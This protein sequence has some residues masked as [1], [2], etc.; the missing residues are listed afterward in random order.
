MNDH[1]SQS[2]GRPRR[3]ALLAGLAYLAL[4]GGYAWPVVANLTTHVAGTGGDAWQNLWNM[5]WF[6][7]ALSSGHNPYF[8]PLLHHPQGITLV[9]QTLNPF[10]CLLAWPLA[11]VFGLVA[12]YNLVFLLSFVAAGLGMYWLG[13]ELGLRPLAA[14]S[15]GA[16][17]TF[18]PYHFAHGTGH[19]QLVAMEWVP[20]YL[21]LLRRLWRRPTLENGLATG[22]A[23]ALVTFCD[24]YYFVSCVIITLLAL[25]LELPGLGLRLRERALVGGIGA[26][27]VAFAVTGGVLVAAVAGA[28]ATTDVVPAHQ[29][30]YWSADLQAFFVPNQISA[31]GAA[32]RAY[33][34]R[35]AGNEAENSQ[36]VGYSV[37]T[38]A[39]LG[40]RLRAKGARPWRFVGLAA[41]GVLLAL[42]PTLRWG[43][44]A[45]GVPLPFGLFETIVPI[46]KL[47]GAPTRWCFLAVLAVAVLAG[48]GLDAVLARL[49]LRFAAQPRRVQ[50]AGV[51][52]LALVLIELLPRFVDVRPYQ[53]PSFV[54]ALAADDAPGAVYDLGGAGLAL[55]RQIGH[56]RPMVGG[57]VSR[58]TR[59][60]QAYLQ[61]TPVLRALRGEWLLA[62]LEVATGAAAIGLRFVILP[63]THPNRGNL[64]RLG[65]R[66]LSTA[67][68]LE[69]WEIGPPASAG[70]RPW[71]GGP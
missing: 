61:T 51:G 18:S 43:G 64:G 32:F 27:V 42:G 9:F 12:A 48:F 36:Y 26:F 68:G 34:N 65:L 4:T 21:L 62:P 69:V 67:G 59:S 60:A 16:V 40:V 1:A 19:L 35:W 44:R 7:T 38:L 6:G 15:S 24:L 63:T 17:F 49:D 2:F 25:A 8:T 57:Y 23:L 37:L 28:F 50:L 41:V 66:H 13:R 11:W 70:Q 46:L 56:G 53:Q 47:S 20:V 22:L 58:L 71:E 31:W 10:N 39:V 3:P 52:F 30:S 45:T 33:S 29:A 5:W 55:V 54:A 14:F